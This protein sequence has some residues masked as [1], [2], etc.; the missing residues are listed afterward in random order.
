MTLPFKGEIRV[1]T[2]KITTSSKKRMRSITI[3][4]LLF[5]LWTGITVYNQ[6]IDIKDK[7]NKLEELKLSEQQAIDT[8]KELENKVLLLQDEEYIADLA[9]KYYFLSKP[10][11]YI[12]I[13]PQE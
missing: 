11:E 5:M 1:A 9:R 6:R 2:K 7:E 10:G 4:L 12:F 13:S 3:L 8:K